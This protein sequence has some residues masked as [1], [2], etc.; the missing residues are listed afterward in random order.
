MGKRLSVL[1]VGKFYPPEVGGLET[2]LEL[3]CAGLARDVEV[4]V[5]VANRGRRTVTEQMAGLPV[6]RAAPWANLFG[7]P[8]CPGMIG[9]IRRS[10]ADIVHLHLPNP[11]AV[12]AYLLS[13]RQG[14]LVA[15]W[16]SDTIR[17]KRLGRLFAPIE[18][19]LLDRCAALIASSPAYVESSPV[20]SARRGLCRVIPYGIAPERFAE[21]NEPAVA[22]LR[23]RYGPRIVLAV[24][25]MVYYKGFQHLIRAMTSVEATLV[26]VGDGPLRASLEK[27][28]E[29]FDLEKRVVLAGRASNE[30]LAALYHACDV[31]VLPSVA[32]SEAFGIVQ[33]EAMACGKPVIN[34]RINSGVGFVSVDGET[35]ISVP[36]ADPAALAAAINRLLEDDALRRRMGEAAASRVREHFSA[37]RMVERTLELYREVAT[38]QTADGG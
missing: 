24:G 32:R 28:V 1:Q 15:T 5:V 36:P 2:H 33:T 26:L 25:R 14:L 16:H 35:G 27:L 22:E 13:G 17:Q 11:G 38:V 4:S 18:G 20:L 37:V 19:R 30:Q 23:R 3:L 29:E 6:T 7:A 9:Q 8:L 12:M 34:T 31:F 21:P 10:K